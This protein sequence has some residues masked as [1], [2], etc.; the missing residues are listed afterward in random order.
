MKKIT[1]FILLSMLVVSVLLIIPAKASATEYPRKTTDFTAGDKT[2]TVSCPDKVVYNQYINPILSLADSFDSG[3]YVILVYEGDNVISSSNFI[4]DVDT[5]WIDSISPETVEVPCT[6]KGMPGTDY[7]E[8]SCAFT[9]TFIPKQFTDDDFTVEVNQSEDYYATVDY[10]YTGSPIE[11]PVRLSWNNVVDTTNK[12]NYNYL[13]PSKYDVSYENNINAGQNTAKVLIK[14]KG[15]FSGTLE[16]SFSINRISINCVDVYTNLKENGTIS[17]DG[18]TKGTDY[19]FEE[20]DPGQC[21]VITLNEDNPIMKNYCFNF[22][23]PSTGLRITDW[24]DSNWNIYPAGHLIIDN[25]GAASTYKN[26]CD[27]HKLMGLN[28]HSTS[29]PASCESDGARGVYYCQNCGRRFFDKDAS[30]E[31]IHMSDAVI[32]ATGHS[33]GEWS[34]T[35][36]AS[37]LYPGLEERQCSKCGSYE[38]KDIPYSEGSSSDSTDGTVVSPVNPG[39]SNAGSTSGGTSNSD[40]KT[41]KT[42]AK[43]NTA[44]V[45]S[46]VSSDTTSE[47]SE[48]SS[49]TA[50]DKT[51]ITK[52]KALKK[53]FSVSWKKV[54]AADGYEIRYST[55]ATMKGAKKKIVSGNSKKSATIKKLK[56]GKRYYV[57]IFAYITNTDGKKIY[58]TV[59]NKKNIKT[60]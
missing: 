54:T 28:M 57:T 44:N 29:Y 41:N 36:T 9:Y 38:Y 13:N 7:A 26:V 25:D 47:A 48:N 32:P 46:N 52:V 45:S 6:I 51:K 2:I 14:G 30:E 10:L 12:T 40:N 55:K 58:S 60:K 53:G 16:R 20:T 59:S 35:R 17:I 1:H 33:W 31:L 11:P 5:S 8:F 43:D 24:N 15:V 50:P 42:D 39:S 34:I 4:L 56:K 27:T 23:T 49:Y 19:T 37:K 3:S 18:L 21:M 22:A